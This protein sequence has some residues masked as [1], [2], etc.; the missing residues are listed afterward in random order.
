[1]AMRTRGRT[2]LVSIIMAA[3]LGVGLCAAPAVALGPSVKGRVFSGAAIAG[4]IV[5]ATTRDPIRR[6]I[7]VAYWPVENE[8]GL[9]RGTLMAVEAVTGD[10]GSFRLPEWGPVG[11]IREEGF[12]YEQ[13]PRILVYAPGYDVVKASNISER[14]SAAWSVPMRADWDGR[15]VRLARFT[16]SENEWAGIL[17]L[18]GA[19]VRAIGFPW[20]DLEWG[21]DT[22]TWRR[23][24]N[25]IRALLEARGQL[26]AKG[27]ANMIP[28]RAFFDERGDPDRCGRYTKTVR[29]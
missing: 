22:C 29:E 27:V 21:P 24:P 13:S 12:V 11:P 4:R 15:E 23:M 17:S 20:A 26:N 7:L 5:D 19:D 6:A 2:L 14:D 25:L 9:R 1:M 18:L 3:A 28:P 8:A 10:D 16:G